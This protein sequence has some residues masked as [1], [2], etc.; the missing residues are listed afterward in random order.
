[1]K[2]GGQN[3]V[4]NLLKAVCGIIFAILLVIVLATFIMDSWY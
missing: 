2:N 4:K 3:M 1:M